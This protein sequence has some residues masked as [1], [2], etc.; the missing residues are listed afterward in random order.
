MKRHSRPKFVTSMFLAA[1][2]ALPALP[3]S[4]QQAERQASLAQGVSVTVPANRS[5]AGTELRNARELRATREGA[6]EARMLTTTE[7]RTSHADAVHRL[8]EIAAEAKGPVSFV[9]IGGW[10]AVQYR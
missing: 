8:S 1:M 9:Q 2:L 3:T 4:A 7:Q 5:R 10:P 6:V